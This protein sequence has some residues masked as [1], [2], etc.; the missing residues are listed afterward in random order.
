MSTPIRPT[1]FQLL[2]QALLAPSALAAVIDAGLGWRFPALVIAVVIVGLDFLSLSLFVESLPQM[3]PQG[4]SEHQMAQYLE[5][6]RVMRPIQILLTPVGL[7]IRWAVTALLLRTMSTALQRSPSGV[8]GG[9]PAAPKAV[10][11]YKLLVLVVYASFVPLVEVMV[12]NF[13]LWGRYGLDGTIVMDPPIGLD[14]LISSTGVGTSVLLQHANLFELWF[15]TL[16]I[17][18]VAALCRVSKR[19][20]AAIVLPVWGFW[21]LGHIAFALV[22]EILTRQLGG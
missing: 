6:S 20:A 19:S 15:V 10:T 13:V 2:K 7:V 16:L 9:N 1:R 8:A 22:K 12:K 21:L 14:V 11:F 17:A 18:G 3:A 5:T 4:L